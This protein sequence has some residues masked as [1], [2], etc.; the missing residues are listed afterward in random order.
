MLAPFWELSAATVKGTLRSVSAATRHSTVAGGKGK[1]EIKRTE[2]ERQAM[3]S[4]TRPTEEPPAAERK[5]DARDFM[6]ETEV[7]LGC[8]LY[9]LQPVPATL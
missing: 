6:A 9:N 5:T 4:V 1:A 8:S 2:S 3:M 7:Q